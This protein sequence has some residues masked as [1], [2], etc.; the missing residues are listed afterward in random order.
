MQHEPMRS[1]KYEETGLIVMNE[2]H[3]NEEKLERY[4]MG[5]LAEPEAAPIEE[6]LLVCA[7][8]QDRLAAAES[9]LPSLRHALREVERD[10]V[11]EPV[12]TRWFAW[13]W[14][15]APIIAGC[16][17]MLLGVYLWTPNQPIEWQSIRLE[18][19]RGD[20]KPA[21]AVEGFA[22]E[23]QLNSEGLENG[24]AVVQIVEAQGGLVQESSVLLGPSPLSTRVS[25][26][27]KPGQYWV[28]LKS[29]GSLLREYALPVRPR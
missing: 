26:P 25:R 27:L 11:A 9:V 20:D 7:T 13:T 8:C 24:P 22:L 1:W 6:H 19:M 15:P 14:A 28:R 3:P 10:P 12:W 4:A 29:G 2:G 23:L 16:A 21:E 18:A 17:A 5:R